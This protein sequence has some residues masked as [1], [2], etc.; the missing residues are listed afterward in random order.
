MVLVNFILE[1]F[2]FFKWEYLDTRRELKTLEI[3]HLGGSLQ[4]LGEL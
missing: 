3:L 4:L 2:F 1:G